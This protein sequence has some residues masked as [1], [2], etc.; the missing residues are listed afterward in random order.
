MKVKDMKVKAISDLHWKGR[1]FDFHDMTGG[2]LLVLAGDIVTARHLKGDYVDLNEFIQEMH[3]KFEAVV[4]VPGNHEYY[5][6]EFHEANDYL[7][8]YYESRGVWYLN[9]NLIII[10]INGVERYIYGGAMWGDFMYDPQK[11]EDVMAA[12]NDYRLIKMGGRLFSSQDAIDQTEKF[13]RSLYDFREPRIDV[14][15]SHHAPSYQSVDPRFWGSSINSGFASN[16]INKV[17]EV[18]PKL[19]VHGHMHNNCD[20][21]I[22]DTRVV[23][24]PRGYGNENPYFDMNKEF[25]VQ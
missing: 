13:W 19:W 11:Q 1:S 24:N 21:M 23:C 16:Y 20:Y 5:G 22:G 15:V 10:D 25:N 17:K 14:V 9:N 6:S 2:D 12:L 3:T 7:R 8:E 18:N 4:V